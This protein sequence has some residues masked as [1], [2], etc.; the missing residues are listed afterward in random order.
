MMTLKHLCYA[1][2]VRKRQNYICWRIWRIS[3]CDLK[4][5]KWLYF[6]NWKVLHS[7]SLIVKHSDIESQGVERNKIEGKDW[8]VM[9]AKQLV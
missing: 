4:R 8:E 6:K 2:R 5:V 7:T 3:L 9:Q 1:L